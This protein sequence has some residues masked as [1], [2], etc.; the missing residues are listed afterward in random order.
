LRTATKIHRRPDA[1]PSELFVIQSLTRRSPI[2][3]ANAGLND[4]TPLELVFADDYSQAT[5][6][7]YF[8]TSLTLTL[9]P[10]RGNSRRP[11]SDCSTRIHKSPT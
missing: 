7:K 8:T 4:S 3:S 9:S 6:Q 2:A 11:F 5:L 10:R 1:T